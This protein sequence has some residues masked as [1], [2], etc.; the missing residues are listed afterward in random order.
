MVT[1]H[2]FLGQ[3]GPASQR[4][5]RPGG[6]VHRPSDGPRGRPQLE[7]F[8]HHP[9]GIAPSVPAMPMRTRSRRLVRRLSGWPRRVAA[10][11]CLLL[12]AVSAVGV[13][14]PHPSAPAGAVAP[15]GVG[16]GNRNAHPVRAMPVRLAAPLAAVVHRGD[17][18]DLLAAPSEPG[19][20]ARASPFG[21][22][23]AAVVIRHV[24]VLAVRMPPQALGDGDAVVV[25][26][27][28]SDQALRLAQYAQAVLL[29]SVTRYS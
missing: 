13:G 3:V 25:V 18:I 24:R 1:D 4:S 7:L 28:R 8:D 2:R 6:V 9:S 10:L 22:A 11:V 15:G 29:V 16:S 19:V 23:A 20:A 5:C 26:A 17:R 14:Q 12:A 27:V 21:A